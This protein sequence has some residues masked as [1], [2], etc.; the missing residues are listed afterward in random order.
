MLAALSLARPTFL[1]RL[2]HFDQETG[3]KTYHSIKDV[4]AGDELCLS[5]GIDPEASEDHT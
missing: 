2:T 1:A 4:K 3:K 5:Y